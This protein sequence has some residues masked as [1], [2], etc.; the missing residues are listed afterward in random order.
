[1][2]KGFTL[3]EYFQIMDA[4]STLAELLTSEKLVIIDKKEDENDE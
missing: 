1:M 2:S 4:L 3:E